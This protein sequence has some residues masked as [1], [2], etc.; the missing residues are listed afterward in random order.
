MGKKEFDL[1]ELITG[2]S[3]QTQIGEH[4]VK[5]VIESARALMASH[6]ANNADR[7]VELH[8]FLIIE[9]EEKPETH[10]QIDGKTGTKPAHFKVKMKPHSGFLRAI[11]ANLP[12]DSP[13]KATK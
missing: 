5:Q 11:N 13:L 8:D 12:A 6:L 4:T 10:W 7:R 9:M 2:I 3:N 1:S